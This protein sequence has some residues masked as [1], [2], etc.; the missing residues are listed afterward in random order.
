[1]KFDVELVGK[2]GS[3]A[4][5]NSEYHDMDYN[6]IARLSREL[7]PGYVWIT[8][9]AV[10]I[11]RLDYV[12]R[13]G[14]ELHGDS[15]DNKTDYS[16]QGQA[17]LMNT[18]RQYVDSRY[19]VRQILV[20]H[21]HFNDE[22]KRKHLKEMLLRCASQNA[23]PIINYN[24]AVSLEENRNLEISKLK[25]KYSKVVQCVDN[26]ETASQIACLVKAE[27]LLILTVTKGIYAV[28][29]DEKTLISEISG[30]DIYELLD[31]LDMCR[32]NCD[33]KSR[34]GTGGAKSKLEYIK[35]PLKLGTNVII[36]SS[37]Y[38]IEDILK[39]NAPRTFIGVR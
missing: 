29:A 21:Q 30:K 15:E 32:E 10:E 36:A 3:M 1:M 18:Y 12:K 23:I 28:P 27:T 26:D 20:E 8:S 37:K 33:G 19:S 24:D 38:S 17:I 22:V 35:E 34:A 2:I 16:A 14:A 7:R 4:L 5:V 6:M 25:E 11:G 13:N 39:G 9:G 31:N